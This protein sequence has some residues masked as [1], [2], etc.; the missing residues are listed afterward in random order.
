ML[1]GTDSML[2]TDNGRNRFKIKMDPTENQNKI[3]DVCKITVPEDLKNTFASLINL[4]P[5]PYRYEK[6]IQQT[7]LK[8]LKLGGEELVRVVIESSKKEFSQTKSRKENK[9]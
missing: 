2:G 5:T 4:I 3:K 9:D 6:D 8:Y 1:L 7:V